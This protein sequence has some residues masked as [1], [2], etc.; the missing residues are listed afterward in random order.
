M[1]RVAPGPRWETPDPPGVVGTYGK[2]VRRWTRR[3]LGL[4]FGRWQTHAIDHAL[5]YDRAGDL[6]ARI[7]LLSTARQN[8]KSVI[9]RGFT[10]WMLDEGRKLEAFRGWREVLA[11]AHD[12]KQARIVYNGV[13]TDVEGNVRLRRQTRTTQFAGIT[14]GSLDF[15][16]V[17]GQP[18][19]ARGHSAGAILWDEMLTQVDFDMWEALGPTQSAQRSPI[20]F[21][22][23]TAGFE[24]S[25]VL[26]SFYDRLRRHA[27]GDEKPDPRFY[28]AWWQSIDPDAGL[29]WTQ[30]RQANPSLGDGRLTRDAISL[31]HAILPPD[32]W[33]RERL[34]HFVDKVAAG[35]YS[36]GVWAALRTPAAL[37]G[38][39]GPFTLGV[40][41]QPGWD[42]ATIS[43]AAI[44]PDGRVG[45]EIYR[46]IRAEP[47]NPV[48]ADRIIAA[49]HTFP[50]FVAAIAYDRLIGAAPAFA[51]DEL[52]T[53]FPWVPMTPVDVVTACMDVDE[54]VL[55]RR[56]AVDDPLLD[57]QIAF[58]GRRPVGLEGG[59]RFSRTVST[60]PIDAI[61]STVFAVHSCAAAGPPPRIR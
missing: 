38:V 27:S 12:A 52:E 58:V 21:L 33:R 8:G 4:T 61:L 53:G 47:G 1:R 49:V 29:D 32:S 11:A 23:S 39:A 15:D 59:F 18:G 44:R 50:E 40:D 24:N 31:D 5:R 54:M 56:L 48:T 20:M 2:A 42:R 60:G 19:S 22:T 25:V 30:I 34:N 9:V 36:P 41:V 37:E 51:R 45:A 55:S 26:R 6:I 7:V 17:T 16:I 10:G 28:A 43:V 35:A 13:R 57:A 46:D 14:S 3:E